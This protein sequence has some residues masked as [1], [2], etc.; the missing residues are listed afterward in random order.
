MA[1]ALFTVM[2]PV[3]ICVAIGFA[4][5]RGGKGFDVDLVTVLITNV[6]APCLVFHTLA[7]LTVSPEAFGVMVGAALAV[8]AVN[9]PLAAG[10]LALARLPQRTFLPTLVFANTGNVGLPLSLLAFGEAGLGLAIGVFAVHSVAMF[11]AGPA[12]AAG[13]LSW[14][15]LLRVPVLYALPPALFFMVTGI[16]PPG[17]INATTGLLGDV[18]IPLMLIALGVSLSRLKVTSAGRSLAL[19]LARLGIGFGV[20][21]GVAWLL[22]LDGMAR[23]VLIL[24]ATMPAAV[25]TYLFAQRYDR[26][27]QE[28]AGV[29]VMS[30]VIGFALMPLLLLYVL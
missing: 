15:A 29:V 17:W 20:G 16:A 5:D 6:G 1:G 21:V 27:P 11:I 26:S 19:S 3:L 28:V 12:L 9:V 23:G 14:R 24:Q 10:V 2:A 18:T 7:N 4:W 8:L 30:T 22:G 25:F 13:T